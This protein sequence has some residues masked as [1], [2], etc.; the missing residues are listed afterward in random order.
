MQPTCEIS[1]AILITKMLSVS[2]EDEEMR[3]EEF[4]DPLHGKVSLQLC[5]TE[6]RTHHGI[7]VPP[8]PHL[9]YR[10]FTRAMHR[11][12][13]SSPTWNQSCTYCGIQL[14]QGEENG[15]CCNKG[16][17]IAPPLPPLPPAFV[18][19]SQRR[20]ISSLS[21]KLNNLFTFTAIGTSN[22]FQQFQHGLSSVA[23]N[24]RI[25]HR[26]IDV[27]EPMHS[28]HWFIYDEVQRQTSATSHGVPMKYVQRVRSALRSVNP[29]VDHLHH[30]Y[31]F[32]ESDTI[33][34]E[35]TEPPAGQDFAAII[36]ANNSTEIEP[37]SVC[38]W[39][40]SN[41]EGTFIPIFSRH[42]EPLQYPLLFP[43]GNLGWGLRYE[44]DE[45]SNEVA[46][47]AVA[48]TQREWYKS[49][50]LRE[51]RFHIF[52]RVTCE[53]LCDMQSRIEEECLNFIRYG[54]HKNALQTDPNID[55]AT[56]DIRLP[57]SFLGS[58]QWVSE[59]A[60]DALALA[61]VYG[62][63]SLFITMTFNPD[64]PEVKSQLYPG[65]TV[66]DIP[67]TVCRVFRQRLKRLVHLIKVKLGGYVY[68]IKVIEFQKRGFPHC[69]I[70]VK[71][72][73]LLAIFLLF[74]HYIQLS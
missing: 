64:W 74:T 70:V 51:D 30:F 59:Q 73:C 24:G 45:D 2:P 33:A 25:Y 11:N 39:Q 41:T 49:R 15:W 3:K 63:P 23:V 6:F 62:K 14:L 17:T 22:G 20:D 32:S 37:R 40:N 35:L 28:M 29:Y 52:G 67:I 53:Y 7:I 27:T 65:Q 34:I 66:H 69:H 13:W 38:I 54:R 72:L 10:G 56:I 31:D 43:H 68:I 5:L 18:Q 57:A 60:A 36:H 50:L 21:R 48:M 19:L 71:V 16:K 42:Y 46:H 61:R 55:T 1:D 47:R 26:M 4:I 9:W 58:R 12:R 44:T 8:D